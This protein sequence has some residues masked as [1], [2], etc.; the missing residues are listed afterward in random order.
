LSLLNAE[1]FLRSLGI[2]FMTAGFLLSLFYFELT[3]KNEYYFYYNKGISK[4][5]LI[6]V[7]AAINVLI[8]SIL[9]IIYYEIIS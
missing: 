6:S 8:G 4:L 2:W 1:F 3:S 7:T 9:I 5:R